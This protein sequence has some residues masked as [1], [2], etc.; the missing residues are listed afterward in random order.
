MSPGEAEFKLACEISPIY[1]TRGIAGN[2]PGATVPLISYTENANSITAAQ[3]GDSS[4]DSFFAHFVPVPGSSLENNAVAHY[5]FSNQDVA[6]NAIIFEP[7]TVS[8][9]MICP[10]NTPGG[11]RTKSSILTSLKNTLRAHNLAGGTYS[12]ATPAYLYVDCILLR[13]VDASSGGETRQAQYRYQLDFYQ[14]LVTEEGA[15]QSYNNL[16]SKI[17]SQTRITPDENGNVNWSGAGNTVGNPTSGAAPTIIPSTKADPG[18]GFAPSGNLTPGGALGGSGP[19]FNSPLSTAVA[20]DSE[21]DSAISSL[22][23]TPG[24]INV[25]S[26]PF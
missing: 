2:V 10:V 11:Y 15:A 1:L 17:G 20:V 24:T 3:V 26:V 4:L 19:G 21:T 7:L 14:P 22:G 16:M 23:Q 18:L 9:V 25:P 8:L 6:A 12:V 13:M 5:P